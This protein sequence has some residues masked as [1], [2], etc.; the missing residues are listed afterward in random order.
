MQR[1]GHHGIGVVEQI[2]GGLAQQRAQSGRQRPTALELQA[3]DD[4]AQHILERADRAH[5]RERRGKRS[6]IAA[7]CREAPD[8]RPAVSHTG[9]RV[10]ASSTRAH[11]RH[12]GAKTVAIS[13]SAIDAM[14]QPGQPAP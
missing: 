2:A 9:D 13:A 12:T 5:V 4:V 8:A 7:G 6:E 1:D 3:V 11:E 10:G 14:E